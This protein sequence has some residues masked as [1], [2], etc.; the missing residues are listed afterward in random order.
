MMTKIERSRKY[1]L[2][3]YRRN[4]SKV[5]EDNKLYYVKNKKRLNIRQKEIRL[6]IKKEVFM[7]Y[8]NRCACCEETIL[9]FLTIDHI[10]GGGREHRKKVGGGGR[11][12]YSWLK[13]NKYPSKFRILCFNCNA[14]RYINSGKCPHIDLEK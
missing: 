8:G 1:K 5:L 11:G 9:A 6:T 14:G 7:A 3:W 4:R 13:R 2:D 12:I 10:N